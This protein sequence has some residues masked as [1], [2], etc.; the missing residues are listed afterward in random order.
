MFHDDNDIREQLSEILNI[1]CPCE[2]PSNGLKWLCIHRWRERWEQAHT[3]EEAAWIHHQITQCH[4]GMNN[5]KDA[6]SSAQLAH[7]HSLRAGDSFWQV[8]ADLLLAQAQGE[9]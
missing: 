2:A 6:V 7:K 5:P 9:S 1:E 3:V 4:L 8:N